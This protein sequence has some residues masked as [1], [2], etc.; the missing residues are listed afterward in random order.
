MARGFE[1]LRD[2]GDL[3]AEPSQP[4]DKKRRSA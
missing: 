2:R 4:T 1:Y 3:T